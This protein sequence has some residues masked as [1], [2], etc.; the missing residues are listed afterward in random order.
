MFNI[1]QIL[2]IWVLFLACPA[3]LGPAW[4]QDQLLRVGFFPNVT[5]AHALIAQN[6]AA[7]GQGWYESRLPGVRISWHSFNAGPSAMESLFAGAIDLTY[8]G[9]NP[10]LN[11]YLRSQGGLAVL[12]GAVRGGAGLVVPAASK[13]SAPAD[14]RGRRIATPQLCNTQDIACRWWL[15]QAGI[16]TS[17]SGGEVRILPVANPEMLAL[18]LRGEIDAAW[19][20]EPWVSR[21]EME[22]NGKLVYAE[23]AETSLTTI[24]AAGSGRIRDNPELFR[25]F[26]AAHRELTEWIGNNPEEA[27]QRTTKELSRLMRREFPL[28]LTR[29]AWPRLIFANRISRED[30]DFSLRAAQTAG[31]VKNENFSLE[32]LVLAP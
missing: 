22:G 5:H 4:G 27:Q 30:F 31:F 8:V 11:A 28:E 29:H 1:L 25:K 7:E 14:F 21:L 23:P 19:T 17:V 12:A 15:D 3:L 20:V 6:M 13:L 24:L 32:N 16:K 26:A 18:F 2:G 10:A 9:P